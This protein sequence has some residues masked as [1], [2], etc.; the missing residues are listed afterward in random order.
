MSLTPLNSTGC[1]RIGELIHICTFATNVRF[2]A[3]IGYHFVIIFAIIL[4]V[5]KFRRMNYSMQVFIK[6]KDQYHTSW[7][8]RR[9]F[10]FIFY[11]LLVR[12]K[13]SFRSQKFILHTK[14]SHQRF[15]LPQQTLYMMKHALKLI[16]HTW[17]WNIQNPFL[18]RLCS[19]CT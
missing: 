1:M 17:L 8:K 15:F 2:V 9:S 11:I 7:C 19:S 14:R 6:S 4:R 12:T 3:K 13:S 10:L 18:H 16:E 5:N